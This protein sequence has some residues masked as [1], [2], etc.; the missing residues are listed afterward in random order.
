MRRRHHPHPPRQRRPHPRHRPHHPHL[1]A[2]HPQSHHRPRPRLHLPQLHHPRP[3]C[4]AHHTT[5]WS[6]GGPTNTD[7]GTLLCTHHHHL[8]HKEQ[9]TI[10][11]QTGI[12]WFI[13]PTP[14]RPQTNTPPQP[15]T[16]QLNPP[17]G[18]RKPAGGGTAA[19]VVRSPANR[20]SRQQI[21]ATRSAPSSCASTSSAPN[22]ADVPRPDPESGRG[23]F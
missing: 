12:P 3:W 21:D 2:P 10:H 18:G 11:M 15:P 22:N 8:I 23:T 9:W 6:H 7:N 17:P 16:P 4:E 1:P 14:H 13:P 5:Y 20:I 19:K